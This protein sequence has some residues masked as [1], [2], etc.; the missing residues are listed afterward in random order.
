MADES[1][2]QGAV[3]LADA[4]AHVTNGAGGQTM[5]LQKGQ[6]RQTCMVAAYASVIKYAYQGAHRQCKVR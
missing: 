4:C 6:G 3:G 2:G 1:I 5:R